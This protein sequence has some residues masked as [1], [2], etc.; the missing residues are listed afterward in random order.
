MC[1]RV[2]FFFIQIALEGLRP[3]MPPGFAPHM[4]KMIS[5]CWNTDPTKRP[6]FD[7]VIPIMSKMVV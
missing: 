1:L 2:F 6:R 5:I 4:A 7:Q 3:S